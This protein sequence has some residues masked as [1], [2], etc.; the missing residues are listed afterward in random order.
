[1]NRK[2]RT[3]FLVDMN[4]FFI[5]CEALLDPSLK[6]APAAVAGDPKKRSGI[7]LTANYEARKFGVRTAMT[8]YQAQKLC[9]AIRLVSPHRELYEKQ[10][11]AVMALLGEFTPA[12]EQNSVDEAW[13]DM[14]GTEG[15]WGKPLE[16]ARQIMA[17][18]ND[19]LGLWCSIGIS[20]NKFLAKMAADMKKPQGITELWSR[21][22][23][24]KLWPLPV[25]DL[26]G[27]GRQTAAKLQEAGLITIGD[28][29]AAGQSSL[30]NRFGK[31]GDE[32]FRLAQ[33]L[34]ESLV[35]P[36]E[37]NEMKSVGRS[38]TLPQNI[39]DVNTAKK[40]IAELTEEVGADLRRHG[41][42]GSTVQITIK[43]ADFRTVT[44]QCKISP[45]NLTRQ[46]IEAA[47]GLLDKNWTHQPVRLLGISVSGFERSAEDN[48]L[49]FFDKQDR[50]DN[51]REE[52]LEKAVDSIRERFGTE[53]VRK[54]STINRRD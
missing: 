8:I 33:G 43:Y 53:S 46:I 49:S 47:D 54:A 32:I 1:M 11:Q 23:P 6:A 2:T 13:L 35:V 29:A 22:V 20:E 9:P 50:N 38:T 34:D 16:T 17:R 45:T 41:K 12:V 42:K 15:I 36:H 5:G 7:I 44:R 3:V 31:Y 39:T 48:Q 28:L 40:V 10:S 30:H 21:D 18:I 24:Q 14:T 51:A 37:E 26:Y 52:S 19:E 4:A 25:G 27:I